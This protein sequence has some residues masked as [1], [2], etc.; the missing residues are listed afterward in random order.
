MTWP[1]PP[2]PIPINQP[3]RVPLGSEDY[4]DAPL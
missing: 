3:T 1:F 2:Q 4:E